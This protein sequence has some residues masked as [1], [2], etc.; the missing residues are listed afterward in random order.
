MVELIDYI[1]RGGVIVY[2]LIGL[3]IIGFTIMFWK[4][5][6]ITIAKFNKDRVVKRIIESMEKSND[7]YEVKTLDN[8]LDKY[9]KGLESG[10]NTVKIIASIAPLLGL[11]GTVVGVLNSFDSISKSGLGDPSVFSTG[12]S[13]ALIT[14]VAGLIVAIPHYVGYNYLVGFIDKLEHKIEEKVITKI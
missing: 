2:I 8:A 13:I 7:K 11:L 6:I 3:N 10:L 1:N 14:T 12:I 4:L 5:I 9:V